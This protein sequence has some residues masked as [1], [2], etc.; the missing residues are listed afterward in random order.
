MSQLALPVT[1]QCALHAGDAASVERRAAL[2]HAL[3][4]EYLTVGWNLFEG[5]VAVG[6]AI[7]AGSIAL[8]GFGVDSFVEMSSGL[9]LLWRLRAETRHR[10]PLDLA[11]LDRRAH[12]LVAL[13]LIL[14]AVYVGVDSSRALIERRLPGPTLV[15][16]TLTAISLPAMLWLGRAKRRVARRLGSHAMESDAFQTTA[17]MWLSL[18]ALVGVGLNAAFGWSWADPLSALVMTYFLAREAQSAWRGEDCCR[19]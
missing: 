3:R 10:A 4:L 12:R 7:G 5:L 8:L 2:A 9:V 16:L 17:C 15:G 19:D 13:S 6:A 14:L 18:T 11:A 1:C